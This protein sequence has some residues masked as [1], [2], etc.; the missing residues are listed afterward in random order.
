MRPGSERLC[1]E[2]PDLVGLALSRRLDQSPVLPTCIIIRLLR[3]VFDLVHKADCSSL[4]HSCSPRCKCLWVVLVLLLNTCS[5]PFLK[6]SYKA[7]S[8]AMN[9]C[10]YWSKQCL[11]WHCHSRAAQSGSCC[12]C[13]SWSVLLHCILGNTGGRR[14]TSSVYWH[15]EMGKA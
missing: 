5:T 1:L 4:T 13:W 14:Y 3:K 10:L 9:I 8:S 2:H 12:F 11:P 7:S 15:P 6:R